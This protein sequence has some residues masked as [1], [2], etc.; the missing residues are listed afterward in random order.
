MLLEG[1]EESFNTKI[2]CSKT[3]EGLGLKEPFVLGSDVKIP[4][5]KLRPVLLSFRTL[6]Q[7]ISRAFSSCE[8]SSRP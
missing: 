1:N 2:Y 6:R 8:F 7:Q 4:F 5:Q 3:P